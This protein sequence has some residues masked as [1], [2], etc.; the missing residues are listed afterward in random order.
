M[1]EALTGKLNAKAPTS[2]AWGLSVVMSFKAR[3]DICVP[4]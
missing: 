1:P 3:L 2:A 4:K